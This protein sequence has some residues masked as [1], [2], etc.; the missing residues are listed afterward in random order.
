MR[1][2]S[3]ISSNHSLGRFS[4]SDNLFYKNQVMQQ[5][6]IKIIMLSYIIVSL[7]VLTLTIHLE[8]L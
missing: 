4:L 3:Y 5:H 1:V 2:F 7:W 6:R 8:L